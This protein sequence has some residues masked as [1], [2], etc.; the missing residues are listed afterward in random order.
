MPPHLLAQPAR[1]LAVHYPDAAAACSVRL[2]KKIVQ[3]GYG[4][5]HGKPV[6]VY[7][8]RGGL[9]MV[10]SHKYCLWNVEPLQL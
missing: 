1:T 10:V 4:F 7:F 8:V 6:Q 5:I 2:V 3:P 9:N